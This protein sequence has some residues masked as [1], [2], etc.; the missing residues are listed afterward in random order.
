MG[1][2]RVLFTRRRL[3]VSLLIR[4]VTWS[5]WSHVE[6]LDGEALI[7][8][9][10]IN[11]VCV[12]PLAHR[13]EI[14][15]RVALVEFPCADPAAVIAQVRSQLGKGYDYLGLLGLVTHQRRWQSTEDWF[16]SELVAYAFESAGYPLFR[17][18]MASRITP[19]SLW[20]LPAPYAVV[21]KPLD[22]IPVDT[23]I[24]R[25]P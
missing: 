1:V 13:L 9:D 25:Q 24:A 14:S 3:P 5:E 2:V 21:N 8:A 19:Q 22:L 4:L 11:G 23:A 16:C 18:N 10:M 6:I 7:G 15:S 17:A 20:L 12:T